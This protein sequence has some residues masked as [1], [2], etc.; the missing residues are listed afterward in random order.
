MTIV[1][2]RLS[3]NLELFFSF[4]GNAEKVEQE[5]L[6]TFFAEGE[7]RY[8]I[9]KENKLYLFEG[10]TLLDTKTNFA[11]KEQ[12]LAYKFDGNRIS[13]ISVPHFIS[14]G[15]GSGKRRGS[16]GGS[17]NNNNNNNG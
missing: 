17:S 15:S 10:D 16:G 9:A 14:M 11:Q 13:E 4:V 6:K 1:N 8:V 12:E 5:T 7:N 3:K 2:T